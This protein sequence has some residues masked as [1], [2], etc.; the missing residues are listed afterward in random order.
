MK[1]KQNSKTTTIA[2]TKDVWQ[3][4]MLFRLKNNLR[5]FNESLK[6][7]LSKT[8]VE[9]NEGTDKPSDAHNIQ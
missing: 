6:K 1:I 5:T 8:K 4:L 9:L 3:R 2:V 7:L